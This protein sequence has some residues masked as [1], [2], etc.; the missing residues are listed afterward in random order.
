MEI[1]KEINSDRIERKIRFGLIEYKQ[2]RN[3]KLFHH[4]FCLFGR[5]HGEWKMYYYNG[6]L[7]E[8]CFFKFGE[9]YGDYK[10]YDINGTL[11]KHKKYKF[12]KVINII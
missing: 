3:G 2:L 10:S 9:L 12:W 6:Q 5:Y 1:I 4:Y 8:H 11:D 7:R